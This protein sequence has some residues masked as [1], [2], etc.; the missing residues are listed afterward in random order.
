MKTIKSLETKVIKNLN[1]I[2]GGDAIFGKKRVL[3]LEQPQP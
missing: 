3:A 2:K 1:T